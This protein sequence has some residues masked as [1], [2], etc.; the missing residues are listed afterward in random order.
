M[1]SITVQFNNWI[2][3]CSNWA[4]SKNWFRCRSKVVWNLVGEKLQKYPVI[5]AP[6]VSQPADQSRCCCNIS[7]L[8]ELT[9]C[10]C[11]WQ[12]FSKMKMQQYHPLEIYECSLTIFTHSTHLFL[13]EKCI[14]EICTTNI[15]PT[16]EYHRIIVAWYALQIHQQFQNKCKNNSETTARIIPKQ[17]QQIPWQYMYQYML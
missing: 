11:P 17:I 6:S 3:I 10:Q 12:A 13:N 16:V 14:D 1:L 5:F 8:L 9:H 2:S 7:R 15:R 4:W